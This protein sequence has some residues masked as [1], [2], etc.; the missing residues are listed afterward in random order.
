MSNTEGNHVAR[1]LAILTEEGISVAGGLRAAADGSCSHKTRT[2]LQQM[3]ER[4]DKGQPLADVVNGRDDIARDFVAASV[5]AGLATDDIATVIQEL[6]DVDS[7]LRRWWRSMWRIVLYPTFIM[8]M[9][10]AVCLFFALW[11]IPSVVGATTHFPVPQT[12]KNLIVYVFATGGVLI[13]VVVIGRLSLGAARGRLI[14]YY[15]PIFGPTIQLIGAWELAARLRMLISRSVTID[16]ALGLVAKESCDPNIAQLC[17]EVSQFTAQGQLLGEHLNGTTRVPDTLVQ[18]IRW[19]ESHDSLPDALQVAMD[20]FEGR[21]RLKLNWLA[22]IVPTLLYLFVLLTGFGF[23]WLSA[24]LVS[25]ELLR[26]YLIPAVLPVHQFIGWVGLLPLGASTWFAMQLLFGSQRQSPTSGVAF[27]LKTVS[28]LLMMFGVFSA[29]T[30][31]LGM[32]SLPFTIAIIIWLAMATFRYRVSESRA[33]LWQLVTAV[34]RGMPMIAAIEAFAHERTDE[35]G[36]RVTELARKL[37]NGELLPMAIRSCRLPLSTELRLIAAMG[38][39]PDQRTNSARTLII[40]SEQR[41]YRLSGILDRLIYFLV[42]CAM[43]VSELKYF[44]TRTLPTVGLDLMDLGVP[45]PQ[46][47]VA[48]AA[49]GDW[50]SSP[51][52]EFL[53]SLLAIAVGAFLIGII[54]Y[55]IGW[56]TWEPPIIRR[57]TA[58]YHGA[59]VLRMIAGAIDRSEALC[60]SIKE[61]AI[62]YPTRYVRRRLIRVVDQVQSGGNWVDALRQQQLISQLSVGVLKSAE[63][64]GNV[65]WA[66]DEMASSVLRHL[67]LRTQAMSQAV[68][69]AALIAIAVPIGWVGHLVFSAITVLI[70]S[71]L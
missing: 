50:T 25:T 57:F 60:D 68:T 35:I 39:R 37:R 19:G 53:L 12:A 2:H 10:T 62:H 15:I 30:S 55:Y 14:M 66:A 3:A 26:T 44:C 13:T 31:I 70:E 45:L 58:R 22:A 33:M 24:Q 67:S 27:V 52:A 38:I 71:N 29:L 49:F 7:V 41:R 20:T 51:L 36:V 43:L 23:L 59:I 18:C 16:K 5:C 9:S 8:L 61:I 48:I 32:A 34:D 56:F 63:R 42:L 11:V 21:I 47:L 28:A 64:S 54:L 69:I 46:R 1:Q 6:A 17:A 4:I 65:P 40:E